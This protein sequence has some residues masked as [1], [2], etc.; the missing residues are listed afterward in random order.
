MSMLK[1]FKEFAMRGNVIDL[2]VGV[3]IGGA[4]GK[5]V[6][7]LVNDV[8]MPPIGL[9]TGGVDFADKKW[10]LKAA[11]NTDPAHKVA[12]VAVNYGVFIN[13]LIQFLIIAFAIFLV[14]KA[15]NRISRKEEAAPAAP[16]ADVVLLTEIRD[17]L[18]HPPQG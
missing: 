5:I 17:L 9:L 2:A 4:F 3:V 1:E 18:K 7:S 14:V 16:P 12:E 8:I 11:D 6:T 10:V 13:T 15:I